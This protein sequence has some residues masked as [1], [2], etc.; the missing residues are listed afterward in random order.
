MALPLKIM[1]YIYCLDLKEDGVLEVRYALHIDTKNKEKYKNI[2][3]HSLYGS[4]HASQNFV[5]FQLI[6]I[7]F[8]VLIEGLV[9]YLF[10]CW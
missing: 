4:F 5:F 9:R 3:L 10:S 7:N 1:M 6:V 8:Y 2:I